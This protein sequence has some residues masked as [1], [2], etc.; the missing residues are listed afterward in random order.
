M[1]G[2]GGFRI[3]VSAVKRIVP[4]ALCLLLFSPLLFSSTLKAVY[5]AA[6]PGYGYDKFIQLET[7]KVYTGGLYIGQTFNRITAEFE[8]ED[9]KDVKIE[10]NG[11]VLDLLGGEICISYCT[12]RLDISDLIIINGNIRYRGVEIGLEEFKPTG[13]V[14]FV[15]FFQPHDYAVRIFGC[16][17]NILLER[18]IFC[19]A[20]D[21][22]PEFM[23]LSG[24]HN[25]WIP[26]GSSMAFS[27][28]GYGFPETKDNWSFHSDPVANADPLR[29]F[30]K[31]CEYG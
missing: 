6:T 31:L 25:D 24:Y 15:T 3:G 4:A 1:S 23:Y 2:K 22:G 21:T 20:V 18:N 30:S 19:D 10:G 28:Q 13:S 26:T 17:D 5:D 8:G 11:A 16:G 29:H 12:N 9:K 7:G 27:A 14:R